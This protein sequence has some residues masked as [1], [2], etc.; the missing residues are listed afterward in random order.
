M[1]SQY[2]YAT[3]SESRAYALASLKSWITGERARCRYIIDRGTQELRDRGQSMSE[4][5][6]SKFEHEIRKA[7][8]ALLELD[9]GMRTS[10]LLR[11]AAGM[12]TRIAE[13]EHHPE[14]RVLRQETIAATGAQLASAT[15]YRGKSQS[16]S[17]KDGGKM[18]GHAAVYGKLSEDLGGFRERIQRGAFSEV[19]KK[20]DARCLV[21][22]NA[23]KLLGR[24]GAG[25]LLL[26]DTVRGLHFYFFSNYCLVFG[27]FW[28]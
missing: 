3:K 5:E 1:K 17:R 8:L 22:H 27:I 7:R 21:N 26:E 9:G 12:E 13:G 19:I 14:M 23:D 11:G 6:F 25:T 4:N 16:R 28:W 10:S 18:W 20:S 2:R 24:Q 15:F